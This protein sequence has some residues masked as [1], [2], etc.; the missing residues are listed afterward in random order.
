MI[1]SAFRMIVGFRAPDVVIL[2]G[3]KIGEELRA[4]E[5]FIRTN[6]DM[7]GLFSEVKAMYHCTDD[8]NLATIFSNA[9]FYVSR[10]GE[11]IE[12]MVSRLTGGGFD[13]TAFE[14]YTMYR[15]DDS[16]RT[17][18]VARKFVSEAVSYRLS[19][20]V[21]TCVTNATLR[22]VLS[23]YTE[24]YEA[25]LADA[26]AQNDERRIEYMIAALGQLKNI[27]V[28][29]R[30]TGG[31]PECERFPEYIEDLIDRAISAILHETGFGFDARAVMM[32]TSEGDVLKIS[33]GC[34]NSG[35]LDYK[36]GHIKLTSKS[37]LYE[38][39]LDTSSF[40]IPA[41]RTVKR[42]YGVEVPGEYYSSARSDLLYIEG[43]LIFNDQYMTFKR[44]LVELGEHPVKLSFIPAFRL[45]RPFEGEWVDRLV[46]MTQLKLLVEKPQSFAAEATLE[47]ITPPGVHVGTYQQSISLKDGDRS[48]EINLPVAIGKSAGNRKHKIIA[49]L[50]EGD[51]T[52]GWDQAHI[53]GQECK[54]NEDSKIALI[55]GTEGLL[56][57]ILRMTGAGYQ[58][59][60]DRYL[61]TGYIGFYDILL[62]DTGCFERYPSLRKLGD[63]LKRFMEFGGTI[64]VFGQ[65]EKWPD[66]ALPVS[67]IPIEHNLDSR[68]TKLTGAAGDPLF[69][70]TYKIG[71]AQLINAVKDTYRSYPARVFP[72]ETIIAAGSDMALLSRSDIGSG[73]L[74]YCGF[75][76]LD[77]FADL[78][79]PAVKFFA[80]LI[81]FSHK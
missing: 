71:P 81:N 57:D 20:A 28:D 2:P 19:E 43:E 21:Q 6:T 36:V 75:P 49:S 44:D 33:T 65:T 1:D 47:F 53:L 79:P 5:A 40:A 78:E 51:R 66:G 46:E 32:S 52:L 12:R 34:T 16:L 23:G 48:Y 24:K 37:G 42:E 18:D 55:G 77:M 69:N 74:I 25:Y 68:D 27:K 29:Y 72:G 59:V 17:G 4:M 63:K 45:V 3:D 64:I 67:I 60:S 35:A 76:V 11:R 58:T 31:G 56:E 39:A 14:G 73:R 38:T 9:A 26:A 61:E 70:K 30:P 62:I 80:N 8:K 41:F 22:N 10:A 15:P 13:P 50:K 7:P 54:I